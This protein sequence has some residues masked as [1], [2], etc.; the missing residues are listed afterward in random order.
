VRFSFWPARYPRDEF[1]QRK[2]LHEVI[3]RTLF[4]TADAVVQSIARGQHQDACGT[5]GH[6]Q[7]AQDLE[8]TFPR[9]H[10]IQNDQVVA[11]SLGQEQAFI[12]VC[13]GFNDKTFFAER[14]RKI[15]DEFLLV[16]D[17]EQT[18]ACDHCVPRTVC[19]APTRNLDPFSDWFHHRFRSEEEEWAHH[20]AP[21][22]SAAS[23]PRL[24]EM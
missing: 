18:H 10:H 9:Q 21:L 20:R 23:I 12:T 17:E 14:A 4:E 15:P 22:G 7:V 1:R 3:I 13:R 5:A 11:A 24:D 6:A 19:Q 2:R 16:F 8:A